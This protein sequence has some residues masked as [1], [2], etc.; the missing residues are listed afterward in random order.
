MTLEPVLCT[1]GRRGQGGYPVLF[2][3]QQPAQLPART[4]GL[5]CHGPRWGQVFFELRGRRHW[6]SRCPCTVPVPSAF[7][8]RHS[9]LPSSQSC[10][11]V[12]NPM[13]LGLS[14]RGSVLASLGGFPNN[15]TG[16]KKTWLHNYK[17]VWSKNHEWGRCMSPVAGCGPTH[18]GEAAGLSSP[19]RVVLG[20]W[21]AGEDPLAGSK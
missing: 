3:L 4:P 18:W 16:L 14:A 7:P 17:M 15:A 20:I 21:G 13:C 19:Q 12:L 9:A 6:D 11:G 8:S 10:H 5:S 1:S 2:P